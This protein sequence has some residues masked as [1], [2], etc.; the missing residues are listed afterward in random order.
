VPTRVRICG[1]AALVIA[2]VT[3]CSSSPG[4][5]SPRTASPSAGPTSGSSTPETTASAPEDPVTTAFAALDPRARVAQLFVVGVHLD[6]LSPGAQLAAD[7]LGGLFLAGRSHESAADLAEVTAGWQSRAPGPGL[8]VAADQEGG[9]VQALQGPGFARLPSG[10][11]QGGLPQAELATLAD[12]M[13][14]ALH[15]AGVN[16][17]LAPVADVVPAGTEAGNAPIGAFDRQYGATGAAVAAAAGTVVQGLAAHQVTATLKHF[18]GLGRVRANTDTSASVTDTVTAAGDDQ[19]SAFGSLLRAPAHPFVMMS[20]AVYTRIDPTTQAAF[21]PAVVTGLLRHQLGF[22]G[23]VISDDLA[24]ARAVRAL[25][26]GERATRFLAAG[27]TLVLTVDASIVPAM[28]DA[29]LA[30]TQADPAFAA[31]VDGAVRTALAA[32]AR[33]GLL[34]G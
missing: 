29:V 15:S 25:P 4:A 10:L 8:W 24:N 17:D 30:R 33:A 5:S 2:L 28:I 14:A 27:G 1:L 16:L 12:G 11:V 7:G 9:Q 23:V 22:D 20:S 31:T 6:D 3:G 21:S 19:V 32:K 13:G 18:P 26:P 34:P